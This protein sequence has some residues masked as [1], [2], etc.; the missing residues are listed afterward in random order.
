MDM[1]NVP[2]AEIIASGIDLLPI[3]DAI[4]LRAKTL[5]AELNKEA[6]T[7]FESDMSA[8]ECSVKSN[9]SILSFS[10]NLNESYLIKYLQNH[11][12]PV[13]GGDNGIAHNVDGTTYQS[14]VP[15][16]LQGTPLYM[17]ELPEID[18]EDEAKQL[19]QIMAPDATENAIAKKHDEIGKAIMPYVEQE[20]SEILGGD[21][22]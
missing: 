17:Y 19:V 20:I 18:G 13:S 7:Q 6:A 11:G 2:T 8:F 5:A 16:Q 14:N 12:T 22:S 1:S 9:G 4:K 10:L 3:N 15:E 21:L